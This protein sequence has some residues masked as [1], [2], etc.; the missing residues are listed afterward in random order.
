MEDGKKITHQLKYAKTESL[1]LLPRLYYDKNII[2]LS[3]KRRKI[4]KALKIDNGRI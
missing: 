1:K 2:C 3:R 4:E